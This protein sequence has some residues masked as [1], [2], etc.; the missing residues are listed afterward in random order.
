MFVVALIMR[1]SMVLLALP[2]HNTQQKNIDSTHLRTAKQ[3]EQKEDYSSALEC[4]RNHLKTYPQDSVAEYFLAYAQY[5]IR[6][7]AE[8]WTTCQHIIGYAPY[9]AKPYRLIGFMAQDSSH[10][11][12]ATVHLAKAFSLDTNEYHLQHSIAFSY[13]QL[14]QAGQREAYQDVLRHINLFLQ[15]DTTNGWAYYLRYAAQSSITCVR[16]TYDV[17][18]MLRYN[19]EVHGVYVDRAGIRMTLGELD[20]AKADADRALSHGINSS[21]V[22]AYLAAIYYYQQYYDKAVESI[23]TA[24]ALPEVPSIAYLYRG[25]IRTQQKEYVGA[26]ADFDTFLASGR[27][28]TPEMVQYINQVKEWYEQNH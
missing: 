4:Y 12:S 8:A 3:F 27:P 22:H 18:R 7:V 15:K 2:H 13:Y 5:R 16:S 1:S 19:P 23:K 17:D 14:A 11:T 28:T 9:Y 20:S 10:H 6:S 25:L 24:F 26:I 21:Y